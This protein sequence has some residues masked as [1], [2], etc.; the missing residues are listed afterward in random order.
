MAYIKHSVGHNY[1]NDFIV[2][3]QNFD[4]S[5][6]PE[7][8]MAACPRGRTMQCDDCDLAATT[9]RAPGASAGTQRSR[10]TTHFAIDKLE[11]GHSQW[12]IRLQ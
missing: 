3:Q 12:I 6:A 5:P 11:W 4:S 2:I 9:L 1:A 8:A 7:A 10:A